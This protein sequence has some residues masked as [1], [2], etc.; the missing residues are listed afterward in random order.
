MIVITTVYRVSRLPGPS[1][2]NPENAPDVILSH[3][4]PSSSRSMP[5][6]VNRNP[7]A[8]MGPDRDVGGLVAGSYVG[9]KS[10]PNDGLPVAGTTTVGAG[11]VWADGD[12]VGAPVVAGLVGPD[13]GRSVGGMLVGIGN[14]GEAVPATGDRVGG[15]VAVGLG[16]AGGAAVGDDVGADDDGDAVIGLTGVGWPVVGLPVVGDVDGRN[17]GLVEGSPVGMGTV[18]DAVPAIG[19]RVGA[20]VVGLG[21]VGDGVGFPVVGL[22]L[23]GATVV[24]GIVGAP[25]GG[26]QSSSASRIRMHVGSSDASVDAYSIASPHV[27][28]ASPGITTSG[29]SRPDGQKAHI[30]VGLSV[31][32]RDVGLFVVGG[33]VGAPVVGGGVGR[34]VGLNVVGTGVVGSGV[35]GPGVGSPVGG[36]VVGGAVV[37][38]D[39]VG[40]GVVGAATG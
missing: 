2:Y 30:A 39:V 4:G 38:R 14:A 20:A 25:V 31:V 11:E 34:G 26:Q 35:V 7:V 36:D 23:V 18:G 9:G 15:A 33:D 6:S 8:R 3:S 37:G 28:R 19:D 40:G 13:V 32:G 21:E 17:V 27:T 5:T 10:K 16:E 1:L 29:S 22:P 24:G 12:P